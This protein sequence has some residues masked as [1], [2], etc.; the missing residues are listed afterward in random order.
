MIFA[1]TESGMKQVKFRRAYG[2]LSFSTRWGHGIMNM[3][4]ALCAVRWAHSKGWETTKV[5]YG[6]TQDAI[7]SAHIL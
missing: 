4:E 5:D 7:R 1:Y 2:T 6:R 3:N